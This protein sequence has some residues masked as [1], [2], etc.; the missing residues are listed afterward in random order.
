M[1]TLHF[2]KYITGLLTLLLLAVGFSAAAQVAEEEFGRNRIQYKTFRWQ[3]YSTPNFDVFFYDGGKDQALRTAEYAEKE[4]KRI[5]NLVG[6]YPY[7]KI[8]LML[9]NSVSDL[10][11]SNVGLNDDRYQTG[12]DNLFLKSKIEIPYEESQVNYK[13]YLTDRLSQQLLN[14]MMYG[15]SLK[16]VLQSSYLLKL[17]EWFLSGV[18]AYLAEGWDVEMDGYMRD[19]MDKTQGKKP[20][21]IFLRNQ[22][23]AG[24]SVW[25]YI[26]ERYGYTAIQNILN[27]TRITRDIEIGISSS[28]NVPYRKFMRD[29]NTH[30]L[31]MN[32][33]PDAGLVSLSRDVQISATNRRGYYYSQVMF[34][35]DGTKLAFAVNDRGSYKVMV[36]DV[37][38]GK[39]HTIRRAGYKTP[40]QKVN[41]KLPLIAWRSNNQVSIVEEKKGGL[42]LAGY[43]LGKRK[44]AITNLSQFTSINSMRY[45]D[46]GKMLVLSAVKNNQAD[47]YLFRSS[48]QP[49]QITNDIF[50][51]EFPV[52]LK[53]S[54]AIAFASNRWLDSLGPVTGSFEKAVNNFDIF[55]YFPDKSTY[56]FKQLTS[57]IS[58]ETQPVAVNNGLLYISE[59]SGIRS[60]NRYDFAAGNQGRVSNY[61]QNLESYDYNQTTGNLTFTATER[62]RQNIYLIKAFAG[63]RLDNGF[64][65]VRQETLE[66][67]SRQPIIKESVK[68][69]VPVPVPVPV[70]TDTA[71]LKK[72]QEVKP[73]DKSINIQNYQFSN[74]NTTAPKKT[75]EAPKPVAAVKPQSTVPVPV[76]QI[77]GPYRYD[78]RF[79]VDNFI[80]SV[81]QDALM[82]F[83]V[84]GKVGMA[85]LFEDH[86][87]NGIGFAVTDFR[88][89]NFYAEYENLRKRYDLK[90]SYRKQTLFGQLNPH[91]YRFTRHEFK[92]AVAYPITHSLSVRAIPQ[93]I[94]TRRTVVT[95]F[96]ENDSVADFAG[97]GAELVFDNSIITGVNMFEGTRMK[98]GIT[99]LAGLNNSNT[100]FSK[101]YADLRHYQKIHKQLIFANRVSYGAFLGNSKKQFLLGG[102]DNWLFSDGDA[103]FSQI[104]AAADIFF[105]QF[106]TPLRGYSYNARSGP[107]YLLYNGELRLPIVQ[108]L[109]RK[110]VYSGFFNN[111]QLTAFF[112]AGTA[113]AGTNPFNRNNSFNT[114]IVGG[115]GNAFEATVVNFRNPFLYG[116]GFGARTTLLGVY[117]KLDVA[118]S[119]QDGQQ[120]G[121]KFFF[122]M[123]YDF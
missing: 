75:P 79:S 87:I 22:R 54:S 101:F 8:T 103:T 55:L 15:G 62:A 76:L 23:L 120:G 84:M 38:S 17:P 36:R 80:L 4:L 3:Y 107:K 35:P 96:A 114:Q 27:L 53:N 28:L 57:T 64:K 46:D 56:R 109:L 113:Y 29:W 98:M 122:T 48:R 78:L 33:Q 65:T 110:P 70:P 31:Q 112:D 20:E 40:D 2:R 91:F 115:N 42:I 58:N 59:E 102:M 52:F 16:E 73:E 13:Q 44:P 21:T 77:A 14:D 123:G 60:I 108:Y 25:N 106:A 30:Y 37:A 32:I 1:I 81:Y 119:E 68:K 89:S 61:L 93:F 11:Q 116:Y 88:T 49:E 85:D 19:M 24:Q 47:L 7:S 94:T 63:V 5:T 100:S 86:R 97:A 6:Y 67:R 43:T 51:D 50:D 12:T 83:G 45:S 34:N 111:L 41:F 121:P 18:S 10:R 9:Y 92:P 82:G 99:S 69:V 71:A 95:K 74:T 104:P 117:G 26:A 105:L 90:M 39:T 118:W 72:P 66:A